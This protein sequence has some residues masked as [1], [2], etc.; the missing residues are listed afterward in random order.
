MEDK[1]YP[2]ELEVITPLSVGAGNDNEWVKGLDFV[3]KDNNVYVIDMQKVAAAGIDVGALTALFLKSD[4]KGISQLLGN[5]IG[6]LSRYVFDMPVKT[7]NN[8]KTFLRTQFYDKPLVAGCSIKGSI[9][10]ALFN[11]L[12]IYEQKNEEVFGTMKDGTDFMRFIRVGDVEMPSTVLVNTK[13]FNLRKEGAEWLGGWK[14]QTNKTTEAYS[15]FGFNTLYECVAP[16]NKGIG[17]ISLAANT[18]SLLEKY[19]QSKSP[20][21]GKKRTLLNEPI[22]CMFQ[23]INDVTKKYL[24]KERAFFLK[25]S[26]NKSDEVLNC[27]DSLLSMI[28]T[29]GSSCLLKMSAGVGFHS[30]T[31]DWQYD[32]YD[33]TKLWTDGRH[34]GKKKYKSRKIADYNQRLQLMGFVRLR[35]LNQEEASERE[36]ILQQQHSVQQ[37]QMQNAVRQR[38]EEVLRKQA[39]EQARKQMAELERQKNEE[40]SKLIVQAKQLGDVEQWDAAIASLQKAATLYPNKAEVSQ[41]I[42]SYQKAKERAAYDLQQLAESQQKLKQPLADIIQKITKA[43]NL[44]SKTTQWLNIES[45]VWSD[46]EMSAFLAIAGRLPSKEKGKLANRIV[47]I[48]QLLSKE[49]ADSLNKGLETI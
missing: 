14:H 6:E 28:P 38:E 7:D 16:G 24:Q 47:E 46:Q 9:R 4:D 22:S 35:V 49:K 37:K 34:A 29:D 42:D 33:K 39:E 40:Y 1:K 32:D 23:V 11:Y 26:A 45:N 27:I 3:Q 2:I 5:R 10:S 8:I 15:S 17:N 12:R 21:A 31:G 18:F 30:I 43:N 44:V 13:L 19:G 36:Q 20:Y 48:T 41:M 25:Y